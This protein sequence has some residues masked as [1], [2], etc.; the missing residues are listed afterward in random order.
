MQVEVFFS[1]QVCTGSQSTCYS[2][3]IA[4]NMVVSYFHSAKGR[5]LAVA[6]V[7]KRQ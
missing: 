2:E 4:A 6:I 3:K 5:G 7:L 1:L